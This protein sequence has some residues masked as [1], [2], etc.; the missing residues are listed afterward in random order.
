MRQNVLYLDTSVLN[1]FFEVK[2][3]EKAK[4]TRKLFKEIRER[5]HR[6]FISDLVLRE[7]GKASALKKNK[8]LSLIKTY[9]LPWL[10]VN[11]ECIGLADNY[12]LKRIFGSGSV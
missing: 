11:E 2:D 4:S 3:L 7:V 5:R 8:L 1:F 10:E 12:M 9:D 6:A